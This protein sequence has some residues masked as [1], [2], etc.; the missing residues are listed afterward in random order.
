MRI[1][2][3]QLE[4]PPHRHQLMSLYSAPGGAHFSQLG[5][6]AAFF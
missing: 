3:V 1:R 4:P 5:A 2:L 6:G